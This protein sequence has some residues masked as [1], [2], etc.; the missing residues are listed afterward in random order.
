MGPGERARGGTG[1]EGRLGT[2][3]LVDVAVRDGVGLGGI[4]LGCLIAVVRG[5]LLGDLVGIGGPAL[6]GE[7]TSPPLIHPARGPPQTEHAMGAGATAWEEAA[8]D[9]FP[10]DLDQ[11][12]EFGPAEPEPIP[13]DDDFDQS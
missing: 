3:A 11:T 8:Q 6:E 7:P 13:E 12:P 9:A 1:G 10:D 2:A 4:E 5:E